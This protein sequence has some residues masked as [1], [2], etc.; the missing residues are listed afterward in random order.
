M[1]RHR[2]NFKVSVIPA[3]IELGKKGNNK[4]VSNHT[5]SEIS[6]TS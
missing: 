4:G 2:N 5:L 3:Q 6:P 1:G